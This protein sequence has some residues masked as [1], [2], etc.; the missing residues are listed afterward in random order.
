M[1]KFLLTDALGTK[2]LVSLRDL[3]KV[4]EIDENRCCFCFKDNLG[5]TWVV[6]ADRA[7]D[8]VVSFLG[9]QTESIFDCKNKPNRSAQKVRLPI[10]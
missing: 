5:A 10:F 8:D 9:S 6:S 3:D 1:N 7:F 2:E 4:Q